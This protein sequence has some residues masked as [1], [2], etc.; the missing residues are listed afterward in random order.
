[1][2]IAPE[3][4]KKVAGVVK[5]DGELGLHDAVAFMFLGSI[6]QVTLGLKPLG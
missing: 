1:M 2:M 4:A 6:E 3:L 5:T